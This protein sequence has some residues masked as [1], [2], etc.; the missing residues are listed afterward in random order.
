MEQNPE[1]LQTLSLNMGQYK[2]LSFKFTVLT[3][4][5]KNWLREL[6]ALSRSTL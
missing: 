4:P 5:G 3:L 2:N 6:R 1:T